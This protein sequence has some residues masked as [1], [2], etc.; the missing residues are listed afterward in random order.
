MKLSPD[1]VAQ[2]TDRQLAQ[3]TGGAGGLLAS[4]VRLGNDWASRSAAVGQLYAQQARG[5]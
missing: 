5:L 3:V 1:Q 4:A 2:L